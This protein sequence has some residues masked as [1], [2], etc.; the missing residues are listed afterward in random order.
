MQG[1]VVQV[2]SA[3]ASS[4]SHYYVLCSDE[5]EAIRLTRAKLALGEER[6]ISILRPVAKWEIEAFGLFPDEVRK[7]P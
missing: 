6:S 4:A 2:A 7:A 1:H 3:D 5:V